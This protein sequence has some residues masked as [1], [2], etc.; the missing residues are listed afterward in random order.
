M[1]FR[2]IYIVLLLA[3]LIS[4]PVS[5]QEDEEEEIQSEEEIWNTQKNI[6]SKKVVNKKVE[7]DEESS[8][9]MF[10]YV[11]EDVKTGAKKREEKKEE[12]KKGTVQKEIR[13]ESNRS[14]DAGIGDIGVETKDEIKSDRSYEIEITRL[15]VPDKRL[16]DISAQWLE[17][18]E[19]LKKREFSTAEEKLK[20]IIEYKLDS[21]IPDIPPIS[22]SLTIEAKNALRAND[23][24]SAKK[25]AEAAMIISPD[26]YE[27]WFFNA[28]VHWITNKTDLFKPLFFIWGGLKRTFTPITIAPLVIGN[29]ITLISLIISITGL[30][31][32]IAMLI[33]N[34]NRIL[35]DLSHLFPYGRSTFL[36]D[37]IWV[38]L[39]FTLIVKFLSI[40]HFFF[41]SSIV[42]WLYLKKREKIILIV[43]LFFVATLPYN[44]SIYN[45]LLNLYGSDSQYIYKAL[46]FEDANSI[47]R[48]KKLIDSGLANT[49]DYLA[50]GLI[51]K[52]RGDFDIA[53]KMYKKS[54]E[55]NA[56]NVAAYNNLA[57]LYLITERYDESLTM[58]NNA[59]NLDPQSEIIRYN[60]SRLF[61]RKKELDKSNAEL[62]EAKRFNEEFVSSALRNSSPSINRFIYDIE[63]SF[64]IDLI[65]I[66]RSEST[67]N[68]RM[69]LPFEHYITGGILTS[70]VFFWII[71]M[72]ITI[73]GVGMM[74]RYINTSTICHRCG[75]PVCRYCSPE[76]TGDSECSQCFHIFTRRD[77]ADPKNRFLKDKEISNYQF[78]HNIVVRM[79]S[80][81]I[82]GAIFIYKNM[83]VKGLLILFFSVTGFISFFFF[84]RPNPLPYFYTTIFETIFKSPFV[85]VGIMA[86]LINVKTCFGKE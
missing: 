47:S 53:E 14:I 84:N 26:N 25:L 35:H 54:L 32:I 34:A 12:D 7:E 45:R 55:I 73:I 37:I 48:F 65:G 21:G 86:Y 42:L 22:L 78:V 4:I 70:D 59:L 52:R 81:V 80:L 69:Y 28:Y 43:L 29:I 85:I 75:R 72:I 38:S 27:V 19:N 79:L 16:G 83:P 5:A 63:P 51:N 49:D 41:I 18:L 50:F 68:K 17:R 56:S 82:P 11:D 9:H 15:K 13:E 3:F 24:I 77:V 2:I 57:N 1:H 44:F 67:S 10:E 8:S 39:F 66:L 61:L 33:R 20:K 76:L 74:S 60:I 31:F 40:F 64:K 58:F 71:I 6:K 36:S 23:F 62:M 30:L 46:K